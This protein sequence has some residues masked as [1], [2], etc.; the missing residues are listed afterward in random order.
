MV[1]SSLVVSLACGTV[2]LAGGRL[3]FKR[4]LPGVLSIF[5]TAQ[6]RPIAY[7]GSGVPISR[8]SGAPVAAG[9]DGGLSATVRAIAGPPSPPTRL[10]IPSL[11]VIAA[12]EPVGDDAQGNMAAP[13]RPE[14]VGW[15]REGAMP[16]QA[17]NAVLDGHLDWTSGPAVFWHL[18]RLSRGDQVIVVR[19]NGTQVN[20]VVD[21]SVVFPFDARPQGLFTTAGP[22]SLALVTCTGPW[23][24]Q[25]ATYLDRLVV[26][27]VLAPPTPPEPPGDEGG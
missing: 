7:A 6:V 14:Q 4:A 23:D 25:R 8:G 22:P 17:G 2:F 18:A 12:V 15:Y 26:H 19:A 24:R 21:S 27:A 3:P 1:A 11:S 20:F 10:V 5:G 9:S 16:G 13:S